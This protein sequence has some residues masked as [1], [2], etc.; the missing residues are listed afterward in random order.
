MASYHN[1]NLKLKGGFGQ[2]TQGSFYL[3]DENENYLQILVTKHSIL[4]YLVTE[5]ALEITFEPRRNNYKF[6]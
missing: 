2:V 5:I 3:V 1:D 6:L 4:T